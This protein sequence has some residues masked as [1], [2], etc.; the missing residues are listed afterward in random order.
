DVTT[1]TITVDWSLH[2]VAGLMSSCPGLDERARIIAQP[3][4]PTG[5]PIGQAFT[6]VFSCN[7][8]S[9]T[10]QGLPA[11]FYRVVLSVEDGLMNKFAASLPEDVDIRATDAVVMTSIVVDGGY[12]KL[13]WIL[14]GNVTNNSL[15][16]AQAGVDTIRVDS[17]PMPASAASHDLFACDDFGGTTNAL[18]A[19]NYDVTVAALLGA[20]PV[21]TTQPTSHPIGMRNQVTD[22]GAVTIGIPG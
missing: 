21:G 18:L 14:R 8:L 13:T 22:L 3:I 17:V 9:G 10:T 11:G 6:A 12:F 19:G 16:C 5:Q 7:A 4:D 15:G 2:T 1:H 20:N